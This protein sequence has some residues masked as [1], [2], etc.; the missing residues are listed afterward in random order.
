VGINACVFAST[1]K[2]CHA[3]LR[4]V[5]PFAADEEYYIST[6]LSKDEL[7]TFV[8]F[9]SSGAIYGYEHE[10]DFVLSSSC[11]ELFANFGIYLPKLKF[12]PGSSES[13]PGIKFEPIHCDNKPSLD[14]DS[15]HNVKNDE[16]QQVVRPVTALNG[17][18]TGAEEESLRNLANTVGDPLDKDPSF[19]DLPDHD[20]HPDETDEITQ[21]ECSVQ[22]VKL[23]NDNENSGYL[24][25]NQRTS[26]RKR[27]PAVNAYNESDSEH[28]ESDDEHLAKLE[29]IKQRAKEKQ[30][31]KQKMKNG[32]AFRNSV[33]RPKKRKAAED[34]DY[35]PKEEEIAEE[36]KEESKK[37]AQDK[38][39]ETENKPLTKKQIDRLFYF[40]QDEALRKPNKR[41]QCDQCVQGFVKLRYL[42]QHQKRHTAKST[43]DRFFCLLCPGYV[44]FP[45]EPQQLAHMNE[46]HAEACLV[47]PQC[48]KTF[49]P[50]D[51]LLLSRHLKWHNKGVETCTCWSCGKIFKDRDGVKSHIRVM[52]KYHDGKCRLCPDFEDPQSW[53]E[54][55]KHFNDVHGGEVQH[56]CGFCPEWFKAKEQVQAHLY[57]DECK[58]EKSGNWGKRTK[59]KKV[60]EICGIEVVATNYE[61][62]KK[63]Y[64]GSESHPCKDCSKVCASAEALKIHR[65]VSHT[66]HTCQHCGYTNRRNRVRTH[67]LL[68]HTPDHLRPYQCKTCGK[69]FADKKNYEMH[70]NVHTGAKPF[71]C[72][73]CGQ[74]FANDGTRGGHIRSVHKS[75][76]RSK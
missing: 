31:E 18:F 42:Q 12:S 40:P 23:E 52:G 15:D 66:K 11:Q 68:K 10:T 64:H 57:A 69:G 65:E 32:K 72:P 47:C 29:A 4:S 76:K 38:K 27:K 48:P 5:G 60:C 61:T 74:G 34:E 58:G 9:S 37:D 21:R 13:R 14:C 8:L 6:E 3:V 35:V 24:E 17:C 2:L 22:L 62:H 7:E 16:D 39:E 71:I 67:I 75:L 26:S 63:L 1:S 49:G 33:G 28:Q 43:E 36:M 55:T 70:Q 50:F 54:L 45:S 53:K 19:E 44:A 25:Q 59:N 30:F 73:H 46:A 56:K 20:I 51:Q 41:W